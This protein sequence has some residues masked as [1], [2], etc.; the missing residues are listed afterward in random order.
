[1]AD[2][3]WVFL[4]TT[5]SEW[6]KPVFRPEGASL[7]FGLNC[8]PP[9]CVVARWHCLTLACSSVWDQDQDE[10]ELDLKAGYMSSK[11]TTTTTTTTKVGLFCKILELHE[12]AKYR[13]LR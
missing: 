7:A 5:P 9:S 10:Q 12:K 1:M 3:T 2:W 6:V 13:A 8:Q 11:T 4:I